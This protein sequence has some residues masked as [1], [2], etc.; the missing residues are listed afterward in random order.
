M[1]WNLGK[2]ILKIVVPSVFKQSTGNA[3]KAVG[4]KT[5]RV[6]LD[7][8]FGEGDLQVVVITHVVIVEVDEALNS[9]LDGCHLN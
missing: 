8:W 7:G 6:A 5:S 4:S 1:E 9:F 3:R 2:E